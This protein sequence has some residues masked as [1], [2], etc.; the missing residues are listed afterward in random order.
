MADP[1]FVATEDI[2]IRRGVC[3]HRAGETVPAANVE[4]N[5]WADKVRLV[6]APAPGQALV[7][8]ES[9]ES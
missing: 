7:P 2:Y 1:V 8:V 6:D 9:A 3:A 4:A 5:G